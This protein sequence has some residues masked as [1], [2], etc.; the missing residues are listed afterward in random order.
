[1]LIETDA[2]DNRQCCEAGAKH[3]WCVEA[4]PTTDVSHT[5]FIGLTMFLVGGLSSIVWG[6]RAVRVV[7]AEQGQGGLMC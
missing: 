4:A 1:M 3:V 7:A 5:R 6:Q 2:H